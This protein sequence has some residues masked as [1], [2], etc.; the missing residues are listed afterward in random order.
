VLGWAAF[1]GLRIAVGPGVFVPRTRTGLLVETA[2]GLLRCGD[3]AADGWCGSGAIGA[4]LVAEVPGVEVYASDIDAVAVAVARRNIRP[5]RVFVGDL[6]DALPPE[7]RGRLR[8]LVANVPYVPSAA[9]ALMPPEAREHEP[10]VA[11][12]GGADG[13]DLLRRI[14]AAAAGWLA[15]DGR[16]LVEVGEE[17]VAG[18]EQAM[19]DAGL[20]S[21]VIRSDELEATVV[22]GRSPAAD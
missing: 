22:A 18:A 1:R 3:V 13:L 9:V 6:V 11:L 21:R 10:R 2:A 7:L 17:Q 4:A 20:E 8:V 16:L 5:D 12:D 15:P 14:A 19:R